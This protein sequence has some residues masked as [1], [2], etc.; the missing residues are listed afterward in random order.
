MRLPSLNL[1]NLIPRRSPRRADSLPARRQPRRRLELEVLEDRSLLSSG[2]FG[3]LS[4]F[5]FIDTNGSGVRNGAEATLAGVPVNLTG[6]TSQGNAVNLTVTTDVSGKFTFLNLLPGTYQ[7]QTG[8]VSGLL[9]GADVSPSTTLG[10]GQSVSQDAAFQ[11]LAPQSLSLRLFLSTTTNAAYP[12]TFSGNTPP[13]VTTPIAAVSVA[14]NSPDKTIDLAAHFG[15]PSTTDTLMRF[16]TSAGPID[17]DLFDSQA[18]QTVA[19]FLNYVTS[20]RYDSTIFHRLVANFVLQGGGFA[21]TSNP[22]NVSALV[23]DPAVAN[24]FSNSNTAGTLAMALQG[25]DINSATDEFFFNLVNNSSSLDQQSFT[26]FGKIIGPSAQQVLN[27]LAGLPVKDE[28]AFN[29]AFNTLPLNNYTGTHFPTDA[30]AANFALVQDA[31][32]VNRNESLTYAVVGNT[33][34][35][36]VTATVTNNRL[37]LHYA[38]GATGTAVITVQASD[39]FGGSVTTSF[40]VTVHP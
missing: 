6:T 36:L 1:G 31:V 9:G 4:G 14:V 23:T 40:N 25:S 39:P 28:S 32:V 20:G 12:F 18:P 26:V 38:A 27:T 30:V 3:T 2:A 16:D 37:N 34:T 8:P 11:G 24:E 7:V 5:A 10:A 21:L 29:A 22:T 17:V 19:N 35:S 33:N 15:D 13:T